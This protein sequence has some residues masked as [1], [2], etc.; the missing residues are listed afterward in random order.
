MPPA[1]DYSTVPPLDIPLHVKY[2][3][4]LDENKDLAYHLTSHLRLNGVYWGFTAL[5]VLGRP[6]ALNRDDMV[7]YVMACW[8]D[9]AGAFGAHVG[10]D[11]HMH[12]TLS[13]IQ[14]LIMQDA[15]DRCNVDRVVEFALSLVG[16]DGSMAGDAFGE[17]DTRFSYLLVSVLSLLGRLGDLDK[18]Y[19]GSGRQR[20]IDH[21]VGSMNF[22][23][24]F[25]SAPGAESHGAQVWVSVASLAILGEL[26][27]V[28]SDLLGWWL[29]ERQLA[30]GGLNG[31]P[32]KLEDV[33]YSWWNL[34]ALSIIGKLHW[35][36][37]DKLI[38]FILSAQDLDGG[39]IA[40]RPDD[41]VDVFHTVFGVAGLS[42]LGYP[43]LRDI[44]PLYCMPRE[45][46]EKRSLGR[47]YQQLPR[48]DTWPPASPAEA[49]KPTQA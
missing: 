15:L 44:H 30:N 2:V 40:D 6:D 19:G 34:A 7:D 35:I 42:L 17:R 13:A 36:N 3:Q 47:V 28:D 37:R 26:D 22:D 41:W 45:V 27:R 23:G 18:L 38:A 16:E 46:I 20:V 10:H 29:A 48:L 8:D 12:A 43:G 21:L 24:A 31:R 9:E 11:A 32:E 25:G 1:K 5:S 49:A 14:I 4:Q 39:G 33:C